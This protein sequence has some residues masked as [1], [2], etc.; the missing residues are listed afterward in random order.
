M[1]FRNCGY[2]LLMIAGLVLTG[3][4]LIAQ[5]K[6]KQALSSV[7]VLARPRKDS[8]MLRWA[9]VSDGLWKKANVNGYM[10]KRITVLRNGKLLPVPEEKMITQKPLLP[11]PLKA[12]E[13]VVK[14]NEKW[15]S[16]AA[17]ALYG[18]S[19]E[20]EASDPK[21][22]ISIYHRAQEQESRFSFALFSADQCFP[23]ARAAA[24]G[25]VDKA[26]D[27]REKYVYQI[28]I[29]DG[30]AGASKDTGMVFTG[31]ADY[32]A[33]P[34]P[35][36]VQAESK[37]R[38]VLLSWNKNL[39][40]HIFNAYIVERSDDNGK[41]YQSVSEEP[42]INT[43][44]TTK[45]KG[46]QQRYFRGDT[47]AAYD[48]LYIYR[49]KGITPFGEISGPSDTVHVFVKELLTARPSITE[50]AI[51]K[52][53]KVNI[54]WH[55]PADAKHIQSFDLERAS[56]M[57][58]SYKKLNTTI[59]KPADS[60]YLDNSPLASNYYR[61]KVM[62]DNGQSAYS[63][64]NFVQLE[65]STA[66]APPTGLKG[67]IDDKGVVQ[68]TWNKNRERDFYAYRVFRANVKTA[69]F[70]QVTRAPLEKNSFTDTINIKTLTKYIYYNIVALDGHFNPSGFSDTL[71]LK[72]PDIIPPVPPVFTSF[73]V[74]TEGISMQWQPS[75]SDDVVKHELLRTRDT[76]WTVLKTFPTGDSTHAFVDTSALAGVNYRY[77][78][79]AE[80]DSHLRGLSTP[81]NGARIDMGLQ[82][83]K[84]L[85]RASV[86]YDKKIVKLRWPAN[87]NITKYWLYRAE[88]DK[89]F[90]LYK[91]FTDG[92]V[93]FSDD[94][95]LI[96]QVYRYKLKS[97]DKN[98]NSAISDEVQVKY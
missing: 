29:A 20:V 73:N 77:M 62:T 76:N 25:Y 92:E 36:D 96:N 61:I 78:V 19:F 17:Q 9:P 26:V 66:P 50:T 13:P 74:E 97:F 64:P 83:S 43:E 45:V 72:R 18:E 31:Y 34:I 63:F 40:E 94:A 3:T 35:Y 65:D 70:V 60:V 37:Q 91:T 55:M 12:W 51:L 27:P 2:G 52:N 79:I 90:K 56:S 11:L 59:L 23:V 84:Q 22:V 87:N 16:I 69:E 33:V 95:L 1:S 88:P 10:I 46:E 93:D 49:V 75:S 80:D 39:Y 30:P 14:V 32:S 86:D 82:R 71:A 54:K 24:L 28:Y 53:G 68:L 48:H 41:T 42:I 57:N 98:N 5:K 89:P 67:K 4:D 81:V 58:G 7:A 6:K 44:P 38:S 15:G 21:S 85:L 8:I 47:V